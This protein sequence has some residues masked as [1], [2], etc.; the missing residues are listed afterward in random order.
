MQVSIC[1]QTQHLFCLPETFTCKGLLKCRGEQ[2]CIPLDQR[3]DGERQCLHGDDEWLC[4]ITC[5]DECS[6]NML[7]YDCNHANLTMIPTSVSHLARKIDL[8]HNNFDIFNN[9][10]SVYH[11]LDT[12][13]LSH[14]GISTLPAQYFQNLANLRYL[15]LSFNGIQTLR[16]HT[17]SGLQNTRILIL[18]DN[19][20]HNIETNTF[21]GLSSLPTLD[22]KMMKIETLLTGTFNGLQRLET[23]DLSLNQLYTLEPSIFDGLVSLR[24][25]DISNNR[26]NIFDKTDFQGL[27]SLV[28]LKSDNYMFCCFVAIDDESCLPKPDDFSS[29][30][31]LMTNNLLRIFLWIL[32]ISAF[33]GNVFV[34]IWRSF[35]H[36]G[37]KVPNFLL[38]NLSVADFLMGL[39][40]LSIASV[41]LYFRGIY[42]ENATWWKTSWLCQVLGCLSTVSSEASVLTL[43]AITFDRLYNIL[44][45]LSVYKLN[46]TSARVVVGVVWLIAFLIGAIPMIPDKYFQVCYDIHVTCLCFMTYHMIIKYLGNYTCS[47]SCS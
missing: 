39:Y 22:L 3:C 16:S 37:Y 21:T 32:G 13:V 4:N 31:D 38:R 8:S 14:N 28:G 15:D 43:C 10:L 42:I 11:Y 6:C 7:S 45:P 44:F 35:Q 26:I 47:I 23:L 41:D 2:N 1:I 30:D 25:L 46:M 29:C 27:S 19:P 24:N 17:F 5:P 36:E 9:S 33:L 34:L 40:M 20:L 18:T 12:L